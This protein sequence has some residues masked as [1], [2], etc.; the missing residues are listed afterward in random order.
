MVHI[1]YIYTNTTDSQLIHLSDSQ[2]AVRPRGLV[3]SVGVG[4]NDGQGLHP[5]RQVAVGDLGPV[6]RRS[7]AGLN[8][9]TSA[10]TQ[11][12]TLPLP[13]VSKICLYH[14]YIMLTMFIAILYHQFK[15]IKRKDQRSDMKRNS[16]QFLYEFLRDFASWISRDLQISNLIW[17]RFFSVLY[18][19]AEI[20]GHDVAHRCEER[21]PLTKIWPFF[22]T[23][24]TETWLKPDSMRKY[25]GPETCCECWTVD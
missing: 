10:G 11:H 3:L 1:L 2:L 6:G 9:T 24:I 20:V 12:R 17:N 13:K 8:R 16:D 19:L 14:V 18:Q 4:R 7:D 5:M 21:V 22:S 23:R 25:Q 15:M